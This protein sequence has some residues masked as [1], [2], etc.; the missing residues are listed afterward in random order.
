MWGAK[1]DQS[2]PSVSYEEVMHQDDRGLFK[3]LQNI[4][5]LNFRL[6]VSAHM[7]QDRFGFS[8]VTGVPV[9]TEATEKLTERIGFI[10]ETQC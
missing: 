5:G 7:L 3:W 6:D 1:I 8:F 10:R 9:T 2:P 4:V